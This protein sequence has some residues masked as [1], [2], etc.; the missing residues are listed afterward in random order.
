[1]GCGGRGSQFRPSP[2]RGMDRAMRSCEHGV[3]TQTVAG[4]MKRLLSR[5][6]E[7]LP[8]AGECPIRCSPR[9]PRFRMNHLPSFWFPASA[10]ACLAAAAFADADGRPPGEMARDPGLLRT[11][12]EADRAW[13]IL[14]EEGPRVRIEGVV[15]GTMP[16]GAFRLHDGG[17]G[18]YVTKSPEGQ[19]LRPRDR[20]IVTGVV[21]KGGYSPWLLAHG[22]ERTGVGEFPEAPAVSYAVLASGVA[23]NQWVQVE[24]LVR[25]MRLLD[26]PNFVDLD[27]GMAGG[28]LRVLINHA[29]GESYAGLEGALVRARGVAAVS[30][31]RHGHVVEPTFRV[32]SL[33]EI[34]ILRPAP[35]DVFDQPVVAIDRLMKTAVPDAP[36]ARVRVV[37]SVTRRMSDTLFFVSDGQLGLKVQTA[38][39]V[40]YLPGD[41][42]DL[43]G[44]PAMDEG[45][46]VLKH[47]R[48]RLVRS[49][50]PPTP[51]R[52][53]MEALLSGDHNSDLVQMR[54]RLIDWTVTGRNVTLTF[55]AGE[56]YFKGL[57]S[58]PESAA[59]RLP[60]RGSVVHVTGICVVSELDDIWFYK[61][62]SFMMLLAG[63][64]DLALVQAPPWWT[65]R[66]LWSALAI[67]II[68]L[69]AVVAWVAALR[70][71][72]ERKRAVIE[73]QARHAAALE[74]RNRIARELHDTLEQGL[75]GLSLQ[76]KA[77]ETDL[78]GGPQLARSRLQ[79]ARQMLRQSR[80]L[81]HNAIREMRTAPSPARSGGLVAGLRR[82]ADS[83]NH[84]GA[85]TV[86]LRILGLS[87]PL[88]PQ[89]E[90]HLLGIGTEAMTNAVK[91]GRA[92]S[93]QVEIDFRSAQVAVR[94]RDN[95]TGF[96]PARC[97]DPGSG[98]FGL[99]GMRERAREVRGDIQINSRPGEGAE[100]VVLAPLAAASGPE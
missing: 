3:V 53:S 50:S 4:V 18:I 94:I 76:M 85:L 88:P 11:V 12:A 55:R 57:L 63:L 87:R 45:L 75:T 19:E 39:A 67:A 9:F 97:L 61:P 31:N 8:G 80:A 72:V 93:I 90:H 54:A 91:H 40:D 82:V 27:L 100:I 48:A 36:V 83:W 62:S 21:R 52:P 17:R 86:E 22:I 33:G 89:L 74:E 78:D 15:T 46:A 29:S 47:A 79:F 5:P 95:G 65:P 64:E 28:N 6:A 84:S 13:A 7:R 71:Q 58:L 77:I 34:E 35:A 24:G 60:E 66:R 69:L 16:S 73:Q 1:M 68:V 56:H 41:V 44:F 14:A 2:F 99:M 20:V 98:C 32:P 43:A 26:P 81:A 23:D 42:V 59:P 25:S 38:T 37:A 49:G 51:A 70:R 10:F 96:D 30:V 92:N